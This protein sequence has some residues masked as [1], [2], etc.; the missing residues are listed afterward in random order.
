MPPLL[1]LWEEFLWLPPLER[2]DGNPVPGSYQIL[3]VNNFGQSLRVNI[4]ILSSGGAAPTV[5]ADEIKA[6]AGGLALGLRFL[7]VELYGKA[8]LF[9]TCERA[10]VRR[11][12]VARQRRSGAARRAAPLDEPDAHKS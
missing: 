3:I 1:S 2:S 4:T 9:M 6:K 5:I 11:A 8:T 12:S 10:L 7:V